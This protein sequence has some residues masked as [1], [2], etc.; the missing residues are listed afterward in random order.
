MRRWSHRLIVCGIIFALIVVAV[1]LVL[2][3]RSGK[4]KGLRVLYKPNANYLLYFVARDK[5]FFAA[6]GLDVKGIE[7]ESTNLMVQALASGQAEFN[8]SNSVPALYA[9]EQNSAGTFKF[10]YITLMAKGRSNNAIIVAKDSPIVRLQDL[11]GKT[12]GT[13]P[14]I[15]SVV[16]A[17]LIFKG[18]L[19]SW[20]G[21]LFKELETRGLLQALAANQLDAIFAIEPLIT[22]GK[23]KGIAKTLVIDAMETYVMDPIPIA[24]GVISSDLAKANPDMAKRIQRAMEKAIDY[25]RANE[26]EC[27]K[28]LAKAI[29]IEEGTANSLGVNTYWKLSEVEPEKVQRLADMLLENGALEKKVDTSCMYWKSK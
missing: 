22:M 8:P 27:R 23:E 7:M 4:A 26:S 1:A 12:V 24:G 18:A 9:A 14:G 3:P 17:Q 5:G 10:L 28:I 13:P 16:M 11:K 21:I 6:E 19:G 25:T 15:T 2:R 29:G 20:E